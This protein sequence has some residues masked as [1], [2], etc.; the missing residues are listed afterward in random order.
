MKGRLVS[1]APTA[2]DI[3]EM[4]RDRVIMPAKTRGGDVAG[5]AQPLRHLAGMEA[6]P[7]DLIEAR[8]LVL[9][10]ARDECGAQRLRK[11]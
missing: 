3:V 1:T 7:L 6:V 5:L 2:D 4:A 11:E 9:V 10:A 8:L